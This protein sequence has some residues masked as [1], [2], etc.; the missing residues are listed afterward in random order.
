MLSSL[1]AN[2]ASTVKLQTI[3]DRLQHSIARDVNYKVFIEDNRN[4]FG[5]WKKRII[6]CARDMNL[7]MV[8]IFKPSDF[9]SPPTQKK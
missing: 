9:Y 1:Q 4:V 2:G 7:N 6:T 5:D 3:I 8:T